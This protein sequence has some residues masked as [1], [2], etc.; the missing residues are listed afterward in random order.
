MTL[1]F[2]R[3]FDKQF[4]KL[5]ARER[6]RVRERLALFLHQ[7]YHPTLRNHA[8]R[9]RYLDYRSIS[10]GGDLRAIFKMVSEEEYVFVT[11]GTHSQ[12]YE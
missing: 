5:K 3:E 9:G 12:L 8:L 6:T 10:I 7:P 11:I 4:R 1:R 2:H